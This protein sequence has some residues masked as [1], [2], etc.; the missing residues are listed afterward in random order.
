MMFFAWQSFF[1]RTRSVLP[2]GDLRTDVLARHN[3]LA[4]ATGVTELRRYLPGLAQQ[5]VATGVWGYQ[6]HD[7]DG[8]SGPDNI[9]GSPPTGPAIGEVF[10]F[11]HVG[12]RHY[13]PST[14][15]FLQR[16]PIGIR[17]GLNVYAY[18]MNNPVR[19]TDPSGYTA[20]DEDV[21]SEIAQLRHGRSLRAALIKAEA[22]RRLV[23]LIPSGA[24]VS[25]GGD[26]LGTGG[27]IGIT[28]T[29]GSIAI[30]ACVSINIGLVE[31]SIE[32]E[33]GYGSN[34]WHGGVD[35]RIG[36]P[37]GPV[38]IGPN[39]EIEIEPPSISWGPVSISPVWEKE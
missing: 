12:A 35:P 37:V 21:D 4:S 15:R 30:H 6:E 27:E 31:A 28:F 16:D 22:L 39:G 25:V 17:G 14:G 34:G 10:P 2:G 3:R 23:G 20:Y 9:L 5:V 1:P 13:D 24:D 32:G 7:A 38:T 33:A 19:S 36:V 29:D 26:I 18:C 8:L 11:L